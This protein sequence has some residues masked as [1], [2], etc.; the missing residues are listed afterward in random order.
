M[1]ANDRLVDGPCWHVTGVHRI[2]HG[3]A[4]I[5]VSRTTYRMGAVRRAGVDTGF[6]GL[7]T[8]AIA[9]W[10]GLSLIGERSL[11]CA[12][13]PGHWE[14]APGGAVEPGEDPACGIE[15]ELIEECAASARAPA[16][17]VAIFF[18]RDAG[19]WEIVHE[20]ALS[21]PPDAPPNWEY[22][23]LAL[24]NVRDPNRGIPSPAAP[25]CRLM[26]VVACRLISEPSLE[27]NQD[28][29][30]APA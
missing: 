14:F 17:P 30:T 26:G 29:P 20:I 23:R 25:S 10:N 5:H 6:R 19:N 12:T 18:D 1:A 2:G 16:K 22:T 28:R 3:G 24:A 11:A 8:K 13:Y 21:A 4:A 7:G 27:A 9:H 15:R